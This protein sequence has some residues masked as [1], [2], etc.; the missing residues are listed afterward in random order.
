MPQGKIHNVEEELQVLNR[1]LRKLTENVE[2]LTQVKTQVAGLKQSITSLEQNITTTYSN[3]AN[4]QWDGTNLKMTWAA[5]SLISK[6]GKVIPVPAGQVTGLSA[7]TEYWF[8]WNANHQKMG[9]NTALTPLHKKP[10]NIVVGRFKTGTGAQSG[11]AGG[12]GSEA[13]GDGHAGNTYNKF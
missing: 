13:G 9:A 6:Q 1:A 7:S 2:G 10:D 4:F 3:N 11:S 12:G 5:F 8:A